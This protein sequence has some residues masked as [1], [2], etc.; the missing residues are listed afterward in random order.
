M[1]TEPC[2]RWPDA[3]LNHWADVYVREHLRD[4]GVL[5]ESFLQAPQALMERL[6]AGQL[7][8]LPN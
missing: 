5:L 8:P 1:P 3:Y 6:R 7:R 4:Y 2:R